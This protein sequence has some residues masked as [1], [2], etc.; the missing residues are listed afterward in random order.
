MSVYECISSNSIKKIL[1]LISE[2]KKLNHSK[3][4][5]QAN[6][7]NHGEIDLM[8][9]SNPV[10]QIQPQMTKNVEPKLFFLHIT[11]IYLTK[12]VI[13]I[14]TMIMMWAVLSTS[15]NQVCRFTSNR[16]NLT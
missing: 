8:S 3:I 6:S 13:I 9:Y 7:L 15:L 5:N 12:L 10:V 2:G 16:I 1:L 4:I 14:I 11:I